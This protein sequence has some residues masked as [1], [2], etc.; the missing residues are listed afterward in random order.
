M[1]FFLLLILTSTALAYEYEGSATAFHTEECAKKEIMIKSAN[2]PPFP[3]ITQITYLENTNTLPFWIRPSSSYKFEGFNDANEKFHGEIVVANVSRYQ[4]VSNKK[5]LITDCRMLIQS[6]EYSLRGF[7]SLKIK[8][9]NNDVI[10][11][12]WNKGCAL[13]QRKY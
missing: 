5:K 12:H 7:F 8:N 1:R 3:Q 6:C 11:D 9:E 10:I 2:R 13:R 4:W